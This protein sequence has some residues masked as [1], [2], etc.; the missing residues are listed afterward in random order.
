MNYSEQGI[1]QKAL[2]TNNLKECHT[3]QQGKT[4]RKDYQVISQ[5]ATK[6]PV[7]MII[8]SQPHAANETLQEYT[9]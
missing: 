5:S 1:K 7:A 3:H 8:Y 2:L 9:Q 6:I 4:L